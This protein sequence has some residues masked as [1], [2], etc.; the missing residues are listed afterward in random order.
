MKNKYFYRSLIATTTL[1]AL[2]PVTGIQAVAEE[3]APSSAVTAPNTAE[4]NT[5]ASETAESDVDSTSDGSK[6]STA[7]DSSNDKE[8]ADKVT[9]PDAAP[10]PSSNNKPVATEAK[11]SVA[12]LAEGIVNTGS[13][14][15]GIRTSFNNYTGG[16]TSVFG[17]ASQNENKNEFTFELEKTSYDPET[18]RFEAQFK[19]GIQYKKY[20]NGTDSCDLDLKLENPRIVIEKEG[21]F[22]YGK[23]TSK[24]YK[25]TETY[26]NDG[27]KPLAQLFTASAEF[28]QTA[29]EVSWSSIP[30]TLTYD[31]NKMFSEFYSVGGGLAPISFKFNPSPHP[32]I[33]RPTFDNAKF[34]VSGK[35]FNNKVPY[36]RHRSLFNANG[37]IL[38]ATSGYRFKQYEGSGLT[39]LDRDLNQLHHSSIKINEYGATAFDEKNSDFYYVSKGQ[40][41][42][43]DR[44][45]LYRVHV[46]PTKGFESAVKVNTFNDAIT[47]LSYHP[48]TDSVAVITTKELAVIKNRQ[49]ELT[50]LPDSASLLQQNSFNG[51]NYD[52]LYGSQYRLD[53]PF[54]LMPMDDGTFVLNADGT[55]I[56]DGKKHYGLMIS[57]NPE[58]KLNPAKLIANSGS[59]NPGL[60]GSSA[61]TN[62]TTIVRVN[63]NS[64]ADLSY[65]QSF[66][67]KDRSFKE[68]TL[69]VQTT[70]IA[71]WGNL[72][73]NKE[74]QVITLNGGNGKLEWRDAQTF[75]LIEGIDPVAI[76][77]GNKTYEHIHGPIL[78]LD[79]GTFYVPSY[80]ASEGEGNETYSLRKVYDP[81]FVPSV[82]DTNKQEDLLKEDLEDSKPSTPI[83]QIVLSVLGG[84][85]LV[86]ALVGFL[87][88]TFIA[89]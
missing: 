75:K 12:E 71:G 18:E 6:E 15:W 72:F 26:T 67:Y 50:P 32:G 27:D 19:G 65:A 2:L 79:E 16:P 48:K 22:I 11:E 8:D 29:T 20:C 56:K 76:P 88:Q 33:K 45:S 23:V 25:K 9:K 53:D 89:R 36:E 59:N 66:S 37:N 31:G 41:N 57:I 63:K 39:L 44:K 49:L 4:E 73:V 85:G 43:D 46:D 13:L 78:Q 83:W 74:E 10:S 35:E 17:G 69:P 42:F 62:G 14:T 80:D 21:S 38:L 58:D 77:N 34:L 64:Y 68:E 3:T 81:K 47:A 61:H 24:Q 28:T 87:F 55:A 30:T 52:S 70:D 60:S 40:D 1:A 54:E 7:P 5:S 51:E 82:K 84:L 86:G